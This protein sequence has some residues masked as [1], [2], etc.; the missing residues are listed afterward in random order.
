MTV[1]R[2]FVMIK[3]HG[4][5]RG[6]VGEIVSR[7]EDRELRLV[8]ARL[9]TPSVELARRHYHV[10]ANRPYF[11]ELVAAI[12]SG[13]VVAMVWEGE[14]SI[15]LV[16]HMIGS[17]RPLEATSG[18]IR[19]D[20]AS[21]ALNSLIHASDN[22]DAADEEIALWFPHGLVEADASRPGPNR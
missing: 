9:R 10:H 16:R 11:R 13:P 6:L 8:A 21:D 12:T 19:G 22:P 3:P 14:H 17:T 1:D 4:V 7:F 20:Y 2:T 18:T 15:A 5:R